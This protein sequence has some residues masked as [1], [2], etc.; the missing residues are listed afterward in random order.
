MVE[1]LAR[2]GILSI[3]FLILA[4]LYVVFFLAAAIE[5]TF[6]IRGGIGVLENPPFL[7]HL[8]GG[9]VSVCLPY[10]IA[11]RTAGLAT[12]HEDREVITLF[13]GMISRSKTKLAL[14]YSGSMIGLFALAYTVSM[15]LQPK[16][17]IYDAVT[18][19]LSFSSYFLIRCYEYLV[20]YPFML[21]GGF[22]LVHYLFRALRSTN[23]PFRPFHFDESGGFRKYYLAVD[24][25][26]YVI[27]SLTVL[28][29][30]MNY[31][32]WGG[33]LRVPMILAIAAP[34]VVTAFAL[35][36]LYSFNRVVELKKRE[37]IRQIRQQ[38]MTLYPAAKDLASLGAK[39]SLEF[40][41][42]LEA[43]ERL[44]AM[45]K[46]GKQGGW[47]KYLLN[48]GL[49]IVTQLAKPVGEMLTA[50]LLGGAP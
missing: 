14:F 25:P 43:M 7:S 48:G 34:S 45:V 29:A 1:W 50:K 46:K 17:N 11:N 16:V 20:C 39:E 24:R 23:I 38:E 32:G 10:V 3:H 5:R 35:L 37:E 15:S 8:V 28:V 42:R 44:V 21:A 36:L 47:Q 12:T 18:H 41:E 26:V 13:T 22:V 49:V 19:P 27:Q 31:I 33:L 4:L 9:A 6:L 30:V 2:R 40:V